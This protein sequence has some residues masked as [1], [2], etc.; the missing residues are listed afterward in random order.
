VLTSFLL[1]ELLDEGTDQTMHSSVISV[2]LVSVT[3]ELIT[4][5][6]TPMCLVSVTLGL[7]V[8]LTLVEGEFLLSVLVAI[9]LNDLLL[10]GG[11]VLLNIV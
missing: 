9:V 11:I 6:H 7:E 5:D 4:H 8:A 1:L 10:I 2:A 3:V